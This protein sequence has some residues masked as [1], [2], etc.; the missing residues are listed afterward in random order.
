MVPIKFS[1]REHAEV[2]I[3]HHAGNK[4]IPNRYEGFWCSMSRILAERIYYQNNF[5]L[6]FKAKREICETNNV[7]GSQIVMHKSDKKVFYI[8]GSELRLVCQ[9]LPNGTM[10]WDKVIEQ[11]VRDR[12]LTLMVGR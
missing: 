10:E 6:L 1:S 4:A 3:R 2:L 8:E 12:Y 5:A 7:D 11:E 9:L